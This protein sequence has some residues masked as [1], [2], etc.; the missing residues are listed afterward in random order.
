MDMP[1][2]TARKDCGS[3]YPELDRIRSAW[4]CGGMSDTPRT[5]VASDHG[6]GPEEM[7]YASFARELEREVIHLRATLA[8]LYEGRA[9]VLPKTAKHA[10]EIILVAEA[11]LKRFPVN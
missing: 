5:D 11:C 7:V 6:F 1:P 10:R 2:Q 9:A 3:G 4:L 8:D